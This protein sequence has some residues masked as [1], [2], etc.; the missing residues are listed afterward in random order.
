MW[1]GDVEEGGGEGGEGGIEGGSQR[2]FSNDTNRS[3]HPLDG[4]PAKVAAKKPS[5]AGIQS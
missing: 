4:R 1:K 3:P 5:A 2:C